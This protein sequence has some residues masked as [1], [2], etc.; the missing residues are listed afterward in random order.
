MYSRYVSGFTLTLFSVFLSAFIALTH[1]IDDL[2]K[3]I[4]KTFEMLD[5]S[6]F[7]GVYWQSYN[8]MQV[9]ISDLASV[10]NE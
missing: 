2:L 7:N 8:R 1:S 10:E 6:L 5:S 9:L 4:K 3:T